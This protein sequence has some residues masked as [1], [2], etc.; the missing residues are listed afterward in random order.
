MK[1]TNTNTNMLLESIITP[2]K[3]WDNPDEQKLEILVENSGKSGIYMWKNKDSGKI[4]V[5]SAKNLKI[6][7]TAYFNINHLTR[8]SN[9]RINR[10]L[11][12]WGNSSFSLTILEYCSIE[13]LIQRE[14]YYIDNLE[15]DYNIC[16]TAGSTLGK[17]HSEK[18]KEKIRN[19]KKGTYGG[20]ANSFFG[21]T[22]TEE[23]RKKMVEA[24]IGKTLSELVK[25]KISETKRGQKF[26]EEHKAN[27]ST[28]Q[29][30]R[31]NVSVLDLETGIETT[32]V[33]ISEAE[34]SMGFSKGS[35]RATLRSKNRAPYKG[36]Y[37]I[38]VI[39]E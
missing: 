8:V 20:E 5:G 11:L 30:N 27:L 23:S 12:K 13:S 37:N 34:R 14:Q 18:A 3:V 21:E 31:K 24:K 9:K 29:P 28:A 1:N 33:S 16:L 15:P 25:E 36:R 10:A 32:Y 19:S 6:R 22:H 35:I 4:Y 39:E 17:L 7:F 26:T 2:V 38:K